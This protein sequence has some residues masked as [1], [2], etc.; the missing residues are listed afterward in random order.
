MGLKDSKCESCGEEVSFLFPIATIQELPSG[1][2]IFRYSGE[3]EQYE[4]LGIP[5]RIAIN[6]AGFSADA[7]THMGYFV[8]INRIYKLFD[9]YF[10][11]FIYD[12]KYTIEQ[13]EELR[14][15]YK[16]EQEKLLLAKYGGAP[17]K[18]EKKK[19]E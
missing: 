14:K 6:I 18:E 19:R 15:E 5:A 9:E 16:K 17:T 12:D 4:F 11:Q 7:I 2:A 3:R 8:P 1:G 10:Y 13:C